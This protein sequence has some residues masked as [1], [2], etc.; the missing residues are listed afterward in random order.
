M[1]ATA[2]GA[3][4]ANGRLTSEAYQLRRAYM[5]EMKARDPH[6]PA[7][8]AIVF[9]DTETYLCSRRNSRYPDSPQAAAIPLWGHR[10]NA[11]G[12]TVF[13]LE[14]DFYV[15]A[16]RPNLLL[17]LNFAQGSQTVNTGNW[18]SN[19]LVPPGCDNRA[20]IENL[21]YEKKGILDRQWWIRVSQSD[22]LVDG[23]RQPD[24]VFAVDK[25][26]ARLGK[27]RQYAR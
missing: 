26:H 14:N 12:G 9:I 6:S 10:T 18:A 24:H 19:F 7:L 5:V 1:D 25:V 2:D 22:P 13:V 23:E 4:I 3:G 15:P 17:T 16:D 8:S 11:S 21:R 27:R 20:R